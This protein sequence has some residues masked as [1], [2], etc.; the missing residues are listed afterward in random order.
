MIDFKQ[1]YATQADAYAHMVAHEDY[2]GNLLPA[3]ARVR[4]FPWQT[5]VE[6]GAGTGR[7][8]RLLSA[9]AQKLVMMDISTHMLAR[10]ADNVAQRTAADNR[11]LPLPDH[12]ADVAL[13]GWTLG[14]L[15][16]WCADWQVEIGL[17]VAEMMRVLKRGGTAVIIETLGTGRKTPQ[18]PARHLAAY[19]HW[20]EQ[21]HDFQ[22]TWIRTDYRFASAQEAAASTRF[23]F[24]DALADHLLA[25]NQT[26]LPECTGIW[27]K[28]ID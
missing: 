1:I 6:L 9:Q 11:R 20:L 24:G 27:W 3:L 4:P 2:E 13:A 28:T 14:H 25:Q 23:F 22:H 21:T 15:A 12:C 18:P 10:A 16:G 8:A 26:I 7:L 5:V 19:Y 17:A